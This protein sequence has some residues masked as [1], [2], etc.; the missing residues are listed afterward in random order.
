MAIDRNPRTFYLTVSDAE[1]N[2]KGRDVEQQDDVVIE[3]AGT[4]GN[5]TRDRLKKAIAEGRITL[6]SKRLL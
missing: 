4:V 3:F 2:V 5:T 6:Q 1:A